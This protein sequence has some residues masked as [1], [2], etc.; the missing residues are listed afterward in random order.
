MDR[1]NYEILS[2]DTLVAIWQNRQ[3]EIVNEALLP[4][5]FKREACGDLWLKSRAIDSR[6]PNARLLKKAL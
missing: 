4:L 3:A 2:G 6:R 1:D 5:F